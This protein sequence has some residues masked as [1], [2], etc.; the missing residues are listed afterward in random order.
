MSYNE[1]VNRLETIGVGI[2]RKT[3]RTQGIVYK[4]VGGSGGFLYFV[5]LGVN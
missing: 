3:Y 4:I 1:L 5:Y 2:N